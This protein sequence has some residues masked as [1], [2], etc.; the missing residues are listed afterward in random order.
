[1]AAAI[2]SAYTNTPVRDDTAMT[3]EVTLTGLVLP[4]GGI[5]DKI[6]AARRAG[7]RRIVLP[8]ANEDDLVDIPEPAKSEMTFIFVDSISQVLAAGFRKPPKPSVVAA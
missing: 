5:K 2:A 3:G 7:L 6:L 8:K 4:V 1:M